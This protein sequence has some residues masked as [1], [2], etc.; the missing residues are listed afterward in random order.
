[1]LGSPTEQNHSCNCKCFA[2]LS[3]VC[4]RL[5]TIH[6]VIEGTTSFPLPPRAV[7]ARA[8]AILVILVIIINIDTVT[9]SQVTT[10]SRIKNPANH[11]LCIIIGIGNTNTVVI[12]PAKT[13]C[14]DRSLKTIAKNAIRSSPGTAILVAAVIA[15]AVETTSKITGR[16]STRSAKIENIRGYGVS[17]AACAC[18]NSRSAKVRNG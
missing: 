12:I 10:A 6:C 2:I 11:H 17:Q 1:M 16:A 3:S 5:L 14:T 9:S 15:T 13:M 4:L 18:K 7:T 8:Q